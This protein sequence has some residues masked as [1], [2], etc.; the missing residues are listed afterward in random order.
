MKTP[1]NALLY[2]VALA[3]CDAMRHT[4]A[5]TASGNISTQING[6][7]VEK[8]MD[9]LQEA[10]KLE[11]QRSVQTMEIYL[12]PVGSG[13]YPPLVSNAKDQRRNNFAKPIHN[14]APLKH[15]KNPQ[16]PRRG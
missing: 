9:L 15:F 14:T 6:P 8:A 13:W 3:V 12:E 2:G 1:N 5:S 7:K 11:T 10:R 16:R 4:G